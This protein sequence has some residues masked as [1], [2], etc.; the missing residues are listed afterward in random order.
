MRG[1]ADMCGTVN[2]CG[3]ADMRGTAKMCGTANIRGGEKSRSS[4]LN[5]ITKSRYSGT[6]GCSGI[7]DCFPFPHTPNPYTLRDN[8]ARK[9]NYIIIFALFA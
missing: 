6:P 3:T 4:Y 9:N 7:A 5:N 2:M 1:A 8:T